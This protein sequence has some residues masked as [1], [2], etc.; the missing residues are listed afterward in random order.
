MLFSVIVPIYNVEKYIRKCIDSILN[1]TY[2]DFELILVDDGSPDNCPQI[3]DEYQKQ[4]DRI[5]V[6]HKENGGLVSARNIGVNSAT[7][8]YICY[9]DGDDWIEKN[10][11]KTLYDK[12]ISKYKPDMVVFGA[13][14]VYEGNESI[15]LSGLPEK[16]YHKNDLESLLYPYMMYD[17]TKPFCSGRIFPV[18]W[19]KLY[20]R[21]LISK[22]YCLD[23]RIRMGEDNAFIFECLYYSNSVFFCDDILYCYNQMNTESMVHTYD[24]TRF[25][26]NLYLTDYISDRMAD[27]SAVI[28]EQINAFKAYWLIM[29]VFHEIK[30]GISIRV[31]KKHIKNGIEKTGIAKKIHFAGLPITAKCFVFL[32]KARLYVFALLAAKIVN[33]RRS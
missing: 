5:R 15:I 20:K 25:D 6:I 23:T 19:N 13:K 17:N 26:N 21:E 27:K 7:G 33:Y 32:L 29:A 12:A 2:S 18:A 28:D 31:A 1:Q 24:A 14:R 9:V 16:I 22:H 8:E 30:S 10:L 3:C 11:L 4:D